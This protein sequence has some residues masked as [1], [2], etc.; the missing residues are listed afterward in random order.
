[1]PNSAILRKDDRSGVYLVRGT[2]VVF[3]PVEGKPADNGKFI[4][5]K[6]I[7]VGDAI[8]EDASTAR[9]GRIQLW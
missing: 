6:G 4:I 7:S 2:R 1:V 8:V 5:T 9:E 3:V